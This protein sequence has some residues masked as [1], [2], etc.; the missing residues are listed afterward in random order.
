MVAK[1]HQA[2]ANA[3]TALFEID[4]TSHNPAVVIQERL[5]VKPLPSKAADFMIRIVKGTLSNLTNYDSIIAKY[6]PEWPVE[7]L[8]V[9]DRNIL[10]M[11]IYELEN[12]DTPVK[13]VIDEAVE[14]A[15]TYGGDNSPR[16]VNGVLGSIV[17]NNAVTRKVESDQVVKAKPPAQRR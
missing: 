11:A 7:Q 6:A 17:R 15:K 8:P 4:L 13:V 10:R 14:L 3:L 9:V 5:D 16:F 12:E 1:R 2:R